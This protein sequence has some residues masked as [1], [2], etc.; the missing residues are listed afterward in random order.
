VRDDGIDVGRGR[1]ARCVQHEQQFDEIFLYRRYQR[2]DHV[3]VALPAVGALLNLQTVVAEPHR[4]S[5]RQR[6]S[7]DL[8]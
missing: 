8:A 3:D 5:G 7:E 4:T 2:L 1:G 6:H